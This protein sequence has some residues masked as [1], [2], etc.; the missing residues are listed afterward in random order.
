MH[1]IQKGS[2][3]GQAYQR[4]VATKSRGEIV[5]L[6]CDLVF[7]L[8]VCV[9]S[10][11]VGAVHVFLKPDLKVSQLMLCPV[12]HLHGG[13]QVSATQAEIDQSPH[14]MPLH[15]SVLLHTCTH[16]KVYPRVTLR[17]FTPF[18]LLSLK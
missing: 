5:L 10:P 18:L 17:P 4:E 8:C 11:S 2:K 9:L 6:G 14:W 1:E 12:H 7:G 13:R 15:L 16:S 3:L